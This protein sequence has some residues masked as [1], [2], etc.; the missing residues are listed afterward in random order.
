[1][2]CTFLDDLLTLSSGITTEKVAG[3]TL[4][5]TVNGIKNPISTAQLGGIKVQTIGPDLGI[6]D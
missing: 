1:M 6:V 5:F 4:K 3:T 2:T